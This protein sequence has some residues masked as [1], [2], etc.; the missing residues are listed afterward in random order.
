MQKGTVV[1]HPLYGIVTITRKQ[2]RRLGNK[3]VIFGVDESGIER[4]LDDSIQPPDKF[5]KEKQ[6]EEGEKM[7]KDEEKTL[8]MEELAMKKALHEASLKKIEAETS[9]NEEVKNVGG[10]NAIKQVVEKMQFVKGE[11]GKDGI[12]PK[13]G[14][15]YWTENDKKELVDEIWKK[16]VIPTPKDGITPEAGIDYPSYKEV[17]TWV[18]DA[19]AA[20]PRPKEVDLVKVADAVLKMVVIPAP[21]PGAPGK[22][23]SPDTP[24]NIKEKLE[25]LKGDDRLDARAIKNL[26]K[27][28]I[29]GGHGPNSL[30]H[31]EDVNLSSP[32][33]GQAL[34]YQ[35]STGKWVNSTVAAGVTVQEIDG[36]PAVSNVTAIKFTNGSVTDNGDGTV[37]VATGAGGGGDVSKVG[38]PVD[39]QVG[40]WTGDGTIEGD[41]AL[42]FNTTTDKLSAGG[43]TGSV[44][45]GTIELGHASDTT[46]SRSAAGTLAVEGVDVLTTSNTK[47]LTNKSIDADTN[48]ITNIENADIKAAAAIAVNK[49]AALT[50]SRAVVSDGSGFVSAATTTATEIGYVNGVTS[51]IQTQLDAKQPLDT[52][53]TTL[54]TAFSSASASGPASLALHEDT[55]NGTNKIT[56]QGVASVASDKTLTLPDATDTLVGKATT[57]TLTNKTI[58]ANGTGNSI[59]NLEVA[60]FA[61]SAIVTAAEGLASSDNDTSVPTTAAVIDGL[62]AKQPL[63]SDLTT[64]AGLTATTDNFI[65]S[66]SSAWASRTPTQVTADLINFVG[67]S[68]SGGTKGLVPAPAAGDAAASKFLK[69]DGTWA[70]ASGSGS[71]AT[72][73]IWDAKGDLAVGTGA[74]T[75]SR[76]AVGTNGQVLTADSAEATGVKWA[77]VAGSG[78]VSKV[79]T[80]ANNQ[81]GVWTGDGTLEGDSALT[82][83]TTT[84]TLSVA[85]SG[86]IAMGAVNIIDDSAGTT[87]L[88]NID[89]LDA[90]TEATVEAA[91]DTLANLTSIQGRTVTLADAGANAIFGWDDVAGAYEN[92]TQ[93]EVLAVVGD[94]SATA[95]GVVELATDAETVTGTD[96]ARATTP[97]NITARLAAPGTIGGTTPGAATFTTLT[98][99]TVNAFTTGGNITLAENT[100][101]DL[102]PAG[103]A[104]GRYTGIAITG[105]A[106]EALAF[107]DV[108]VLDV[109]AGK[110]FKG[111]V[112]AAAGADGD[113]R[114]GVGMCVLAAAGDASATKI[115]L[116]GT[117]R[118]DA[119][120]PA[121]TVGSVVYATTSGD[122]TVTR[123]STTDHVIKILGFALT[124]DEIMFNPS[125][126]WM[127]NV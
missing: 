66:K 18:E 34:S 82:F 111:S 17:Q 59:T 76:L 2:Y 43:T 99:T 55:D 90:T 19:V 103:S 46:L 6:K 13:R 116:M 105:T 91:I 24:E 27:T 125:M 96:T 35:S 23:G 1:Y 44:D 56:I 41:T 112:S 32:T 69:A 67:D 75:A 107:G 127:V 20:I 72:D 68:G 118:A 100:S 83:D 85:A 122:I 77:T 124:A 9:A 8:K 36:S 73:A 123:P 12:I 117:C 7:A 114:G 37:N 30:K 4:E 40:V 50:A 16:V 60:D 64:I 109:T 22:D 54:A 104:D 62:D 52:D 61:G 53:L 38:T 95:K 3:T 126:D 87:T 80:P 42:T 15:D 26:P 121:L 79:G 65:Q 81:I 94:S 48:T 110:W 88:S 28:Q 5:L 31:L 29:G 25:S 63:D 49:L 74:N 57:D 120:F 78:D 93:A 89:A 106:G 108:I 115:L 21:I 47:T 14:K 101:L 98:A 11:P 33:N 97:A 86:K 119:N 92:L 39:N 84:D 58:D 10:V 51:A 45:T 71:V 102:D 70:A 113:L